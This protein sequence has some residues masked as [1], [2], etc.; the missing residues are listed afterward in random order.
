LTLVFLLEISTLK[1][2]EKKK[3]KKRNLN[4]ARYWYRLTPG[5]LATQ[6]VEIRRIAV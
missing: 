6:E 1:I 4:P 5:I 3:E 2:K